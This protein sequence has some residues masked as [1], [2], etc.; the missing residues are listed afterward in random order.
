MISYSGKLQL[1]AEKEYLPD[2]SDVTINK[3]KKKHRK[4]GN[5]L[6]TRVNRI[7]LQTRE[8]R[9]KEKKKIQNDKLMTEILGDVKAVEE[10]YEGGRR[11]Y[12]YKCPECDHS[13]QG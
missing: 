5:S 10:K 9:R 1:A 13:D 2:E 11:S 12:F 8:K 7:V 6:K 3:E 4:K